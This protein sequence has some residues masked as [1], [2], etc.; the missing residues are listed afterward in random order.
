MYTVVI[1]SQETA[2]LSRDYR[3]LFFDS[4]I[5]KGELEFCTW[6]KSGDTVETAVPALYDL[7]AGKREWRA[8]IVQTER[9][10]IGAGAPESRPAN[11]FD[12]L[13]NRD[14]DLYRV[15]E[16]PVP[17][18]RLVQLLGGVPEP[19][20]EFTLAPVVDTSAEDLL[21][22]EDAPHA[23]TV[24]RMVYK[25]VPHPEAEQAYRE[26]TAKY[27]FIENRPREILVI[28]TRQPV[29]NTEAQIKAAWNLRLESESSEFWYRNRYPSR[30]RFLVCD[31]LD[32]RH[33]LYGGCIFKLW[34]I[35]R[36]LA[37]NEISA[38]S[39]QAY[40]LYRVGLELD[41]PGLEA[42]FAKYQERMM[43]MLSQLDAADAN[44]EPLE[45][46]A[47]KK[48]P[49][50]EGDI[51]VVFAARQNS[52]LFVDTRN[53]GLTTD[54]PE[55]ERGFWTAAFR[56]TSTALHELLRSPMRALDVAAED[57]R[58]KSVYEHDQVTILNRYQR[59]DLEEELETRYFQVLE[60]RSLLGFNPRRRE[61]EHRV[62]NQQV[63]QRIG[64]RLTR[65]RAL[66]AG[67]AGLGVVLL[68]LIPYL[69]YAAQKGG[70]KSFL[71]ALL[72]TVLAVAVTAGFGLVELWIQRKEMADAMEDHNR[73]MQDTVREVRESAQHYSDYLSALSAYLRG[74]S[75]LDQ[76]EELRA[77]RANIRHL[78]TAHRKAIQKCLGLIRSWGAALGVPQKDGI[79]MERSFSFDPAVPPEENPAYRVDE[80]GLMNQISL[81]GTG[82]M[83]DCPYDFIRGMTLERE[84]L[85][86]DDDGLESD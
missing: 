81:N 5:S 48:A 67:A 17:L 16:S 56:R 58:R 44:Q 52:A 80:V 42:A 51:D 2:R 83:L 62:I 18:V 43:T 38:S 20:V 77:G 37:M 26:L 78:R 7:I 6:I 30:C 75:Y 15:E 40:R 57:T 8:I 74:R 19:E 66:L 59:S 50:M 27:Q 32:E 79:N 11:P 82:E 39:L 68:G 76:E 70:A 54:V 34:H 85:Y 25:P 28:S 60:A 1:Q 46:E 35:V 65:K 69:I 3:R 13:A 63:H 10:R 33:S 64:Q 14:R 49:E 31:V 53:L 4:P 24:T 71:G 22:E 36:L 12:F 61:K 29:D 55:E 73:C 84:E 86:E 72:I 47:A 9:D 41:Q 21:E 23:G 45:V